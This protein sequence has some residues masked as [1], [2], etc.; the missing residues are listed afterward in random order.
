VH[1]MVVMSD[2]A[3]STLAEVGATMSLTRERIRQ[4]E[5]KGAPEAALADAR[6]KA[7]QRPRVARSLVAARGWTRLFQARGRR[8][9][10]DLHL[11]E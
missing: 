2:G 8:A 7:A 10:V 6:A 11:G 4:I 9:R 5:A 3:E 1:S